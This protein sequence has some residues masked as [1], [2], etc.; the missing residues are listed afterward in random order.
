MAARRACPSGRALRLA[1]GVPHGQYGVVSVDAPKPFNPTYLTFALGALIA[2]L[3]GATSAAVTTAVLTQRVDTVTRT[4]EATQVW[5]VATDKRL[6]AMEGD[7]RVANKAFEGFGK[8]LD[9]VQRGVDDIK[10]AMMGRP[11]AAVLAPASGRT[12]YP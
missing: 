6:N 10:A 9:R 3:S 4:Q 2:I 11:A 1:W 12:P 8:D 5:M 7:V